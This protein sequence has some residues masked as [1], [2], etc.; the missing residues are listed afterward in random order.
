MELLHVT[1]EQRI[2]IIRLHDIIV[3]SGAEDIIVR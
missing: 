3:R 1:K 2:E